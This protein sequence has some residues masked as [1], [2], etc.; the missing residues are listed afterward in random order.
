MFFP[1]FLLHFKKDVFKIL[2]EMTNFDELNKGRKG[3]IL[4]DNRNELLP[5]VRTTSSYI[6]P[7][8]SFNEIHFENSF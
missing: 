1:Q 4:L 7:A 3:S 5:I 2:S 8:Q 6:S